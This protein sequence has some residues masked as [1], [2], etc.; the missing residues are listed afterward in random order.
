MHEQ[1]AP[2]SVGRP[3]PLSRQQEA[4][5]MTY[6]RSGDSEAY[7]V[8]AKV[9][10]KR[11][12]DISRVSQCMTIISAKHEMLRTYYP[13]SAGKLTQVVLDHFS[14]D[15]YV[16]ESL[17]PEC[18]SQLSDSFVR[19][20][21]LL[22]LAPPFR[23]LVV[24]EGAWAV[25][26]LVF[27]H[28][29]VDGR[30][31]DLIVRQFC[32]AMESLE[33]GVA[34]EA[35]PVVDYTSYIAWS[36]SESAVAA[37]R[38]DDTYWLTAL[39]G[40]K[41]LPLADSKN[42]PWRAGE[43]E[44]VT[45]QVILPEVLTLRLRALAF[46][47]R[48][49]L[50]A[51][52]AAGYATGL[53]RATGERDV[54]FGLTFSGRT[55]LRFSRTIGHF[56]NTVPL[57][58][59][60]RESEPIDVLVQRVN[61]TVAEA[62]QHQA[63][64]LL[65]ISAHLSD[66]GQAFGSMA[67]GAGFT[68]DGE[69][70]DT[71]LDD[72]LP[73]GATLVRGRREALRF[74]IQMH[75]WTWRGMLKVRISHRRAALSQAGAL[76]LVDAFQTSMAE[77]LGLPHDELARL[78]A[79]SAPED[80]RCRA[81]GAAASAAGDSSG[82]RAWWHWVPPAAGPAHT[83][84]SALFD[85]QVAATPDA[86]ALI[87]G[88]DRLT[89]AELAAQ[90]DSCAN[91][92]R[93]RG[94][95]SEVVVGI[96]LE[97]SAE[98]IVAL[99][100]V[101]RAGGAYLPLDPGY[102]RQRLNYM[103]V[104][105]QP[106]LVIASERLRLRLPTHVPVV[107]MQNFGDEL[108]TA[109]RTWSPLDEHGSV[110][111]AAAIL[112]T[113][114]STG[115]PK[116]VVLSHEGFAALAASLCD[117]FDVRPGKV[118][119][120]F[121][122]LNFDAALWEI[123]LALTTGAALVV[124]PEDD[125]HTP[126]GLGLLVKTHKVTH[127]ACTP[128]FLDAVPVDTFRPGLTITIGGEPSSPALVTRWSRDHRL[129]NLYGPAEVTICASTSQPLLVGQPPDIGSAITGKELHVLGPELEPCGYGEIGELYVGGVGLARGYLRRPALTSEKFVASPGANGERLYRTGD[130]VRRQLDGTLLFVGRV[131][132]QVK[133]NGVRVEPAEVEAALRSFPAVGQAAVVLERDRHGDGFLAGHVVP[134]P[135]QS[136][137]VDALR[138]HVAQVLPRAL[139]PSALGV[140]A[141][142]PLT[143]NGKLDRRAL[144]SLLPE[145]GGSGT[146]LVGQRASGML[147]LTAQLLGRSS[148]SPH[149]NFFDL[150]GHSLLAIRLSQR[151]NEEFGVSLKLRQIFDAATLRDMLDGH[152]ED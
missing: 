86:P 29:A 144:P 32:A 43:E 52:L 62:A 145:R 44:I 39:D 127:L 79:N 8:S 83:T 148:V 50:S 108:S 135:G 109:E 64:S 75:A 94:V 1:R 89:Y 31:R 137:D 131:D 42:A 111:S 19:A 101:L 25:I 119:L 76:A 88:S 60:L 151:L 41:Q 85:E 103:I 70:E 146:P 12:L 22:D 106:A 95:G 100:G 71:W 34:I 118:V 112:Y 149:E 122:S 124:A 140:V 84:L 63:V 147:A 14:P 114:G 2:R 45:C 91:W 143:P 133:V 10:Y 121:F 120:Q 47:R 24:Q 16:A 33:S 113:S 105:A 27:H 102:P 116:A 13:D 55:H 6:L 99:L 38:D 67:F 93:Q 129:I 141:M 117:T 28:I 11:S 69:T 58:V 35:P 74:D 104:D 136:L 126:S 30:S 80:S 96:M 138:T 56:V 23:A 115:A 72:P 128:S 51:C 81:L 73:G 5:L 150:G 49:S 18:T 134:V 21:F 15:V 82:P 4:M 9:L 61:K 87:T 90:V 130:L 36:R 17:E 46:R 125:V 3:W 97:R 59:D 65:D 142:L 152:L 37:R 40:A 7:H 54:L 68:F 77:L 20:P 92:L 107:A 123:V 139:V 53:G 110:N 57:R 48:V 66:G 26:V 132:D 98:M 78:S